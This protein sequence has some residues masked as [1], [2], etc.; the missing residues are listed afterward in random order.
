MGGGISGLRRM[1]GMDGGMGVMGGFGPFPFDHYAYAQDDR[2]RA[3]ELERDNYDLARQ[4]VRTSDQAERDELATKIKANLNEL[5][6]LKLKGYTA[7]MG[8]IERELETLREKV[9]ER[10]TN[11]E[12]IVTGR[13][14]ELVGED[15]P[16]RW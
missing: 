7:K 13:F 14:K 1:S 4:Y 16:L 2:E 15:N 11:K 8:A 12:L 5:F 10:K 6:D 9:E 3:A